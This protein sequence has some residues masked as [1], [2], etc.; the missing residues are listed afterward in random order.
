[1]KRRSQYSNQRAGE[2]LGGRKVCGDKLPGTTWFSVA[3]TK[4][5]ADEV[6]ITVG[7]Y[8]DALPADQQDDASFGTILAAIC[9]HWRR[10]RARK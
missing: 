1:M 3:W 9:N 6:M 2:K 10:G 8:I 5:E 4:K 7:Q